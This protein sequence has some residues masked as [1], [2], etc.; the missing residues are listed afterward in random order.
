MTETITIRVGHGNSHSAETYT[1]TFQ[2]VRTA[3]HL[4]LGWAT[5]DNEDVLRFPVIVDDRNNRVL[6][7][8]DWQAP[9]RDADLADPEDFAYQMKFGAAQFRTPSGRV[10]DVH[11]HFLPMTPAK[12]RAT[13]AALGYTQR[14]FAAYV[15]CHERAVRAWLAGERPIPPWLPVMLRLMASTKSQRKSGRE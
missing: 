6:T 1:A 8:T 15:G 10:S 13:L 11:R 9:W 2:P 3:G 7:V 14:G 5:V 12:F 4:R